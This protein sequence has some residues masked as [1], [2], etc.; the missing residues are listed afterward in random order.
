MA[1]SGALHVG[2]DV[3]VTGPSVV[4]TGYREQIRRLA[5]PELMGREEELAA[6]A[7]FCTEPV[8]NPYLWLRGP[9]WTGKSALLSW[10]ALHPP[11]GV[12]VVPF[13]I[14]ARFAGQNDRIGF[15]EVMMEQLAAFLGQPLPVQMTE[16]TREGHLLRLVSEAA[17]MCEEE[18]SRLVLVVDGLD[19][20]CGVTV[21]PES[22]S[23]AALLPAQPEAGMR[24]IVASR[25]S[26]P[27][28]ADVRPDHLLRDAGIVRELSASPHAEAV[29]A[30]AERELQRLLEASGLGREILG[31]VTTAGGGLSERDLAELT[32]ESPYIVGRQIRTVTGRTFTPLLSPWAGEEVYV[33]GHDELRTTALRMLDVGTIA[34][35]RARLH[36]WADE[37]RGRHWPAD[38]PEY[39]FLGYFR[40]VQDSGDLPRMVECATDVARH[41][42]MLGATGGDAAAFAEIAAAQELILGQGDP[43]LAAMARLVVHRDNLKARNDNVPPA[44]PAL[45]AA[46]G[47]H[48]RAEALVH[49]ILVPER[50]NRALLCLLETLLEA[51]QLRRA[52]AL[53]EA[54]AAPALRAR[55]L[56]DVARAA[57]AAG[58]LDQ[59]EEL[60]LTVEDPRQQ[61]SALTGAVRAAVD[62]QDEIRARRLVERAESVALGIGKTPHRSQAMGSVASSLDLMGDHERA[63]ALARAIPHPY[64]QA[65]T[66][67]NLALAAAQA[68]DVTRCEA[69]SREAEF[70][71]DSLSGPR[72]T[73]RVLAALARTSAWA[74]MTER[75]RGLAGRADALAQ[76]MTD[77]AQQAM[78]LAM[79]APA[80]AAAGDPVRARLLARSIPVTARRI[81]A[82]LRLV[83][84]DAIGVRECLDELISAVEA[85]SKQTSKSGGG[86]GELVFL[87]H[88]A[89]FD[90]KQR[91]LAE[92]IALHI[93]NP[94]RR[95]RLLLELAKSA[96]VDGAHHEAEILRARAEAAVQSCLDADESVEAM[97]GIAR[98]DVLIGQEGRAR[99]LAE[100]VEAR[101]RDAT[102][103]THHQLRALLNLARVMA[104][105]GEAER[106]KGLARQVTTLA[107]SIGQQ[108]ERTHALGELVDLALMTGDEVWAEEVT[109]TID[110]PFR[111]AQALL[112]L[113]RI[114][115]NADDH[116]RAAHCA[117]EVESLLVNRQ[118][119]DNRQASDK[120][121]Q[122]ASQLI[123]L[124]IT[125]GEHARA[126]SIAYTIPDVQ[127]QARALLKVAQHT[128]PTHARRLLARVMSTAGWTESLA[129]LAPLAPA[130][131]TAVVDSQLG[132]PRHSL[133]MPRTGADTDG[134]SAP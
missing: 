67:C 92:T 116:D 55:A 124:F 28:P 103:N 19:E 14:T 48:Q 4:R 123:E 70:L 32:G 34:R 72:D 77:P 99:Q 110:H 104:A 24:V 13:F 56:A 129:S 98:V 126:E 105:M 76:G 6:L 25:P 93:R 71:A 46:L 53:A 121:P 49:S 64:K 106:V 100:E 15:C 130:V 86:D 39:L 127:Q 83:R 108:D 89:A 1:V 5:P 94:G 119:N 31:L 37:Y 12:R 88:T 42:R 74:G 8:D 132:S 58:Q 11:S 63:W 17:R 36:R 26:P 23:I 2:G 68:G 57:C 113:A 122:L 38:A 44:L 10:F 50:R 33:L 102:S 101:M 22:Y 111:R 65:R 81:H 52:R 117:D 134:R 107:G 80:V 18:G 62:A 54:V 69:L 128:D 16:A 75:A 9:A 60:C 79:V 115:A 87:A 59:G 90:L 82:L 51:G 125:W 133:Y 41:N 30:D 3:T 118:T 96:A 27:I 66:L 61:V 120:W 40:M 114:A 29:R 45:W 7:R 78:A 112:K 43:D 91:A 84:V 131:V 73:A 95:V 47:S 85:G 20:D 97:V 109:R 35:H 21:R